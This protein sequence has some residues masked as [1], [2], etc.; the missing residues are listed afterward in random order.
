MRNNLLLVAFMTVAALAMSRG[1]AMA[2]SIVE[3]YSYGDLA[4]FKPLPD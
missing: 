3:S 2:L 4:D 1:A